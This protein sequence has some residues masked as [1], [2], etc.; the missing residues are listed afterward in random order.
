MVFLCIPVFLAV[1]MSGRVGY[2]TGNEELTLRTEVRS[3]R[4]CEKATDTYR[5][6][7]LLE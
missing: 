1:E 6:Q 4:W 5:V 2:G 3:G 7:T